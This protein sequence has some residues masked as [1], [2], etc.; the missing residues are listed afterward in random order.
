M[1]TPT[2]CTPDHAPNLC[3][4]D[5]FARPLKPSLPPIAVIGGGN[6]GSA[7]IAGLQQQGDAPTI[8]VCDP[9]DAVRARHAD[10]GL[11]TS[12]SPQPAADAGLVL[13]AVKPQLVDVVLADLAPL[14]NNNHLV[15]SILAGTTTA[16]IAAGLAPGVRVV[17][18]MPN[19]PIAVG[20]RDG[21]PLTLAQAPATAIC[22]SPSN[23]SAP[24]HRS[25]TALNP[26]STPSPRSAVLAPPTSSVLLNVW[27][28]AR[29]ALDSR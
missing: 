13:L 29:E 12:G 3:R 2:S 7:I 25:S 26:R 8:T 11:A 28:T 22:C 23:C 9:N 24:Q 18:S 14:L 19:T 1:N 6:M 21:G 16:R 5:C 15:V 4:H 27:S 20:L 10:A 17:R